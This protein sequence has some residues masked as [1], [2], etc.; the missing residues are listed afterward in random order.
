MRR[1]AF[2]S[3]ALARAGSTRRPEPSVRADAFFFREA[4]VRAD[5]PVFDAPGLFLDAREDPG[6]F[7]DFF[8]ALFFFATPAAG[9]LFGRAFP[10]LFFFP[11]DRDF[12]V[13][14]EAPLAFLVFCVFFDLRF[15]IVLVDIWW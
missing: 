4:G 12:T 14:F 2:S 9:F 10:A 1:A 3:G 7:P 8:S 11:A 6:A 5:T 13:P 15:A